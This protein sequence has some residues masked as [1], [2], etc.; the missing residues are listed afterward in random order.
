MSEPLVPVVT[1][2][3]DDEDSPIEL[4]MMMSRKKIPDDNFADD[5][6]VRRFVEQHISPLLDRVRQDRSPMEETWRAYDKMEMLQHDDGRKYMGRSDTYVP[7]FN[8]AL[9]TLTSQLIQGLFP[10]DEY[11]DVAARMP[12]ESLQAKDIKN[13][14]QWEFDSVANVRQRMKPGVRQQLKYGTTAYKFWYEK[15]RRKEGKLKLEQL[16]SGQMQPGGIDYADIICEGLRVSARNMY[17]VYVYPAT[18]SNMDEALAVFEDIEVSRAFLESMDGKWKNVDH[19]LANGSRGDG[20]FDLNQLTHLETAGEGHPQPKD[21]TSDDSPHSLRVITEVWVRLPVPSRFRMNGEMKGCLVPCRLILCDGVILEARRNT[22]WHQQPPFLFG[23][24]NVRPGF[25]YGDGIGRLNRGFQYLT[26]DLFNQVNDCGIYSLN[27]LLKVNPAA[28]VGPIP[29]IRPGAVWKMTDMNAVAFERPPVELIQYGLQMVNAVSA[30]QQDF[31]GAPPVLQG[32]KGARTATATSVLNKNA[33]GPLQDIIEDLELDVMV[34]LMKGA[35]RLGQQFR[36]SEI[37]MRVSGRDLKVDKSSL[38]IDANCLWLA[39][40]QA[41][42]QAM[43]SQQIMQLLQVVM[44]PGMLQLL[45]MQGKSVNPV[46]LIQR[47]FSDGF[48]LRGF[49][50]FIVDAQPMGPP[51]MAPGQPSPE[52]MGEDGGRVRAPVEQADGMMGEM[53]PGPGETEDFMDTRMMADMMAGAQGGYGSG[54]NE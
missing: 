24:M 3:A 8:R 39:S 2:T 41:A 38:A 46:P 4:A 44:A 47:L 21:E 42:N 43:R 23:R 9:T 12:E 6:D 54:G 5:D 34:P 32:S 30:M 13:Y 16:I 25:F 52:M 50:Q 7:V 45:Q 18:A 28:I 37:F 29:K 31:G 27:P 20:S 19:A 48:G 53:E 22:D 11:M 14:L 49:D 17:H 35:W 36:P 33:Q 26:N 1:T 51:G 40:S 15:T 10:S